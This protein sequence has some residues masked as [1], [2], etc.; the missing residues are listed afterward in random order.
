MNFLPLANENIGLGDALGISGLGIGIV[1]AVLA[2]LAVF[3]II[4]SKLVNARKKSEKATLTEDTSAPAEAPVAQGTQPD[5]Q[6]VD[7][8]TENA[9]GDIPHIPGFVVL[10]GVSE[11][12]AA[13]LMAITSHKTGIA[14]ERLDFKS[15]K[16]LNQDPVLENVE[17]QD[18]AVLM[19]IVSN[20]TGIP[21]ENLVFNSI[22]LVED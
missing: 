11:Q 7:V 20:K 5:E 12:D 19:A 3:V 10:D 17:E 16:R 2:V 15:I 6:K 22:K 1:M 4:L 18:A 8:Q 21:L 9:D 13:V 14:L